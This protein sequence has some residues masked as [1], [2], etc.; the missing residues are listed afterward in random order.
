MEDSDLGRAID[1]YDESLHD[2]IGD[3]L[4]EYFLGQGS[5]VPTDALAVRK[6]RLENRLEQ[7]QTEKERVNAEIESVTDELEMLNGLIRRV[8][9]EYIDEALANCKT[10]QQSRREP[11]NDAIQRQAEKVGLPPQRFIE[12]LNEKYPTDRFGNL[13]GE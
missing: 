1:H 5:D 12:L 7:L 11:S 4:E 8:G 3:L 10:I 2:L 6:E 13:E 9:D